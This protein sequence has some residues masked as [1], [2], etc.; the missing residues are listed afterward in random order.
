MFPGGQGGGTGP[1]ARSLT[2]FGRFVTLR[3]RTSLHRTIQDHTERWRRRQPQNVAFAKN[4][5][6]TLRA[7]LEVIQVGKAAYLVNGTCSLSDEKDTLSVLF[8][9]I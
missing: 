1:G 8:N 4:I 3:H 7:A 2:M 9:L 5:D 6:T